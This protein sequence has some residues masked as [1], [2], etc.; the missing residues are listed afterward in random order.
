MFDFSKF[1]S[2]PK[3]ASQI[4]T[5]LITLTGVY[6]WDGSNFLYSRLIELLLGSCLDF[7]IPI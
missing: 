2:P 7:S 6:G 1:M 5:M 4:W 3:L